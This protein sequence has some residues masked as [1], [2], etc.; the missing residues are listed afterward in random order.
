MSDQL[1]AGFIERAREAADKAARAQLAF[2]TGNYDAYLD[3][4]FGEAS[5]RLNAGYDELSGPR[6]AGD[7]TA[8]NVDS[9]HE[10]RLDV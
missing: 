3:Q 4:V 9:G 1:L 8:T 7:G 6:S 2:A 5:A 10:P